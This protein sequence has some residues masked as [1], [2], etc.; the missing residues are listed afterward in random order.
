MKTLISLEEA[1][2][3]SDIK[4][5]EKEKKGAVKY[6]KSKKRK[7]MLNLYQIRMLR[8]SKMLLTSR[9]AAFG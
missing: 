6:D 5:S 2:G 7:G 4:A 3:A 9:V 8:P 1:R